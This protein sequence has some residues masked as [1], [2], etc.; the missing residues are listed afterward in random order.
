MEFGAIWKG[1]NPSYGAYD[2]HGYQLLTSHGM[3]LQVVGWFSWWFPP[4]NP[5]AVRYLYAAIDFTAPQSVPGLRPKR[6]RLVFQ[7]AEM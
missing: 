7:P 4:T 3:I 5:I 1:K 2:H 6:P